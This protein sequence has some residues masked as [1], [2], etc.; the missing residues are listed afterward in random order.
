MMTGHNSTSFNTMLSTVAGGGGVASSRCLEW[1]VG[2]ESG[3]RGKK[4]REEKAISHLSSSLSSS[5]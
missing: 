5:P 2:S 3:G 4:R 1:E